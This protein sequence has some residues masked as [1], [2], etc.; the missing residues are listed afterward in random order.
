MPESPFCSYVD[1]KGRPYILPFN[2]PICFHVVAMAL[3]YAS[4]FSSPA[5]A[6]FVVT[7]ALKNHIRWMVRSKLTAENHS[8]VLPEKF[9]VCGANEFVQYRVIGEEP[10]K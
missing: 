6:L 2:V 3:L 7:V 10:C 4:I 9:N 8:L 5:G 1:T